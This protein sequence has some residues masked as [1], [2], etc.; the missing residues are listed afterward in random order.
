MRKYMHIALLMLTLVGAMPWLDGCGGTLAGNPGP[1]KGDDDDKTPKNNQGAPVSFFMTDAP[2]EDATSVFITATNIQVSLQGEQWIDIPLQHTTEIDLL[3]YQEGKVLPLGSIADLPAG[4]YQQ[5][6]LVLA[7]NKSSRLIDKN[8]EEHELKIPSGDE[9]GLKIKNSFVVEKDKGVELTLD[10]DLRKSLKRPGGAKEKYSLKPVLRMVQ[11][12]LVGVIT[13]ES[14]KATVAC[15]YTPDQT[16]DA[17][18][19]CPNSIHS[20]P[21]RGGKFR[22]S[23]VEAGTYKIRLFLPTATFVDRDNLEVKAGEVLDLGKL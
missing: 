15:L 3:A 9:S 6:R 22:L 21:V 5:T 12:K 10:F 17:T 20:T 8:G 23:F 7:E 2:V 1:A 16:F 19:D 18:D 13:G 4:T 11:N 14:E